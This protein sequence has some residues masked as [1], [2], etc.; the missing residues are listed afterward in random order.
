IAVRNY[1]EKAE[2][3]GLYLS[4]HCMN[5]IIKTPI[6][7]NYIEAYKQFDRKLFETLAPAFPKMEI[8]RFDG[9]RKDDVI[10]IRLNPFGIEWISIITKDAITENEAYF[11]DEG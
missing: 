1:S 7:T 11:I 9:S 8:L 5:I 10:H 4:K 6:N 2:L 3:E